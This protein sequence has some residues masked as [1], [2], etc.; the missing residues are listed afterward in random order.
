MR[1]AWLGSALLVL[2]CNAGTVIDFRTVVVGEDPFLGAETLELRVRRGDGTLVAL[3]VLPPDTRALA[4]GPLPFGEPL[5]I[6]VETRLG[7]LPLATGRSFPFVVAGPGEAPSRSPD[8]TLGVLGRHALVATLPAV[9]TSAIAVPTEAGALLV[10]G[11]AAIPFVAHGD[12][13]RPRSDPPVPLPAGRR[14]GMVAAALGGALVIG[15]TEPG[16][17]W[18]DA[19][20]AAMESLDDPLLTAVTGGAVVAIAEDVVV[21]IGGQASDGATLD[22][23]VRLEHQATGWTAHALVPLPAPR[24]A[25]QALVVRAASTSGAVP[26]VLVEGGTDGATMNVL[27]LVVLDP[28]G[29]DAPRTFTPPRPRRGEALADIAV[30]QVML[31]GGVDA[32]GTVVSDVDVLFVDADR[33][34]G[35]LSPAPDPLFRA[36]RD[37]CAV[38]LSEG[39]S[40]VV[41]GRDPDGAP[42]DASEIAALAVLPGR[43]RL[44]GSL[45]QAGSPTE[46]IR[47]GDGT[48]LV[49]AGDRASLY[50]PFPP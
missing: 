33:P 18:L 44:T 39:V 37:A 1:R 17:T 32:A 6:E 7:A 19:R 35:V 27:P 49:Y 41:G 50:F 23:V 20:G 5:T 3:D 47:L 28:E 42:I 12:D 10:T 9:P 13:G 14:G 11:E 46:A 36:R 8:V 38:V 30:G 4:A 16:A 24:T 29:V 31:A 26:R 22:A 25:A 48:V 45:P 15:G 34:L 43:V 2:G 40:L 21:V